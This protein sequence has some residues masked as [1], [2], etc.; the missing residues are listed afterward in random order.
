MNYWIFQSVP[1]HYDLR[2]KNNFSTGKDA[3]WYATRYRKK[4]N[5]GDTVY[6]WMGG[7]ETIR[8]IYGVGKITS[9]PYEKDGNFNIDIHVDYRLP[10]HISVNRIKEES[11]LNNL[12]IL[13]IA[14]G[15]NF[16]INTKEGLTIAKIVDFYKEKE[17][18]QD[19]K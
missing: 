9:L 16:L 6:F 17:G 7:D 4:M 13:K 1:S 14:I 19:A 8:G 18:L 11:V 5:V 2:E 10:K 12:M 3:W 15:S